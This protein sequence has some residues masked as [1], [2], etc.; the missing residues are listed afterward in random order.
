MKLFRGIA[1]WLRKRGFLAKKYATSI[2][3][4]EQGLNTFC[5]SCK[6]LI[7]PGMPVGQAWSGAPYPF[8][9]MTFECCESGGLYCGQWGEGRLRTLHEIDPENYPEGTAT[10]VGHILNTG[11]TVVMNIE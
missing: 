9:H 1:E 6:R 7:T 11:N 3:E 5:A 10:V 8:T 2:G 4:C